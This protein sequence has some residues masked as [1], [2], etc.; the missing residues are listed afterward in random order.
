VAAHLL[1]LVTLFGASAGSMLLLRMLGKSSANNEGD[2]YIGGRGGGVFSGARN[3]QR[4]GPLSPDAVVVLGSVIGLAV[5]VTL[6]LQVVLVQSGL[7]WM[8]WTVGIPHT[9]SNLAKQL[10][11]QRPCFRLLVTCSA[12][13]AHKPVL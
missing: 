12:P 2:M 6:L 13:Q 7:G 9:C 5:A 1:Y 3:A 8:M 10:G 11:K 4:H